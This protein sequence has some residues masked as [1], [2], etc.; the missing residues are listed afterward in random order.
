M[1]QDTVYVVTSRRALILGGFT[2]GPQVSVSK[3]SEIVQSFPPAKVLDYEMA[4]RG[5][6]IV[7]GGEWQRD[8]RRSVWGHCGFLAVDDSQA[9]EAAIKCLLSREEKVC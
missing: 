4:G 5:R 6:D 1:L 2:W 8:R 9:A 3:A 7:L